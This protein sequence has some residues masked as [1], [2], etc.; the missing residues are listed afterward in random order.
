LAPSLLLVTLLMIVAGTAVIISASSDETVHREA[1]DSTGAF[2]PFVPSNGSAGVPE[3]SVPVLNTSAVTG[4]TPGLYGGTRTDTCNAEGIRTYLEANPDK[5]AAWA[6]AMDLPP[7]QVG[8]FLSS[9]TPVTLRTDSAVTNH[10]FRDGAAT[11][12]QSVLQA[13]TAVL[14]D[15]QGLPRVR[16]YCGNPLG[17][18]DRPTSARYEGAAWT[19]FSDDSVTVIRKAPRTVSEFVVV[20]PGTDEVI[21]RP[22]GTDGDND[23][24]AD[25]AVAQDVRARTS[26]ATRDAG[27]GGGAAGTE[28]DADDHAV[29]GTGDGSSAAPDA[30]EQPDASIAAVPD[31]EQDPQTSAPDAQ[32]EPGPEPGTGT[33]PDPATNANPDTGTGTSPDTGTDP[34][35]NPVV[36][37]DVVVDP[38]PPAVVEDVVE[39]T[40]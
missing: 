31:G 4:D 18:P 10:G 1:V 6:S 33:E 11:A 17:E 9:L 35:P 21:T 5:A 32:L 30:S 23:R 19:G 2:P 8:S 7:G 34:D 40:G 22:V 12:F 37:P 26:Y 28:A 20:D 27:T 16:C 29:G 15:A 3:V 38:A 14:V 39:P 13:G 25:P 24:P 36:V